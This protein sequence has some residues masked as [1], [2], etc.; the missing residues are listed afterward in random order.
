MDY[1]LIFFFFAIAFLYSS[2]GFGGGSSYLAILSLYSFEYRLLRTIALVCNFIV[3]SGG[4]YLFA[5]QGHIKWKKTLPLVFVS[6]PLAFLGA[7]IPF[8]ENVFFILLGSTLVIAGIIMLLEDYLRKVSVEKASKEKKDRPIVNGA[9][10]GG[11]GLLAGS[12]GIGGGIF[13][14]PLLHIMHWDKAKTIAGTASFFILINS[15]SGLAGQL[16]QNNLA[17][18]FE[19]ILY[20]GLSVLVGGQLGSRL[21]VFKLSQKKVK[22][23]TAL[24]V[25][26]AG[27]RLLLKYL[28]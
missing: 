6:V 10:G 19:M 20:L 26:F 12:V 9:I 21:S 22:M 27:G 2:V 13:L 18:D 15:A 8:K 24:L 17:F 14:S 11:I 23:L 3:V 1:E 25:L 4:T 7:R 28:V 5:K 16:S